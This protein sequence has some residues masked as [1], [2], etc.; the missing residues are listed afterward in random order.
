LPADEVEALWIWIRHE[1]RLLGSRTNFF[2]V[3]E[4]MLLLSFATVLTS[5]DNAF[6][7]FLLAF[8]GVVITAIWIHVSRLHIQQLSNLRKKLREIDRVYNALYTEF[9]APGRPHRVHWKIGVWMSSMILV[10][11]AVLFG[12]SLLQFASR[13]PEVTFL[14]LGVF[15]TAST[16]LWFL[17]MPKSDIAKPVNCEHP[18]LLKQVKS[19]GEHVVRY[20]C[21][22]CDADLAM[23]E[24]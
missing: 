24:Q 15:I 23:P 3:A 17:P 6:F 14:T 20:R 7:L 9:G 1:D 2:L 5:R 22:L 19:K 8:L 18:R 11:W 4:S 10:V 13:F 12:Y 21:E 16:I